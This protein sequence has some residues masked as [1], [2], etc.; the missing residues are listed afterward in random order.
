VIATSLAG[1]PDARLLE[2][3]AAGRDERPVR[4]TELLLVAAGLEPSGDP[5]LGAVDALLLDFREG[6]FGPRVDVVVDCPACGQHLEVAF[7][8]ADLRAEPSGPKPTEVV[9]DD[10][11]VRVRFRSPTLTDLRAIA[12]AQSLDAARRMLIERCIVDARRGGRRIDAATLPEGI[13]ARVGE[14]M[15]AADRQAD[16]RL[17]LR[18]PD[19]GHGWDAP[20]DVASFLWLEIDARVRRLMA[21]VHTLARAYGWTEAEILGLPSAR[22][23]AYLELILG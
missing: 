19:C 18:C 7:E 15:A 10:S 9:S 17:G 16:L 20:F 3:W 22:R 6:T 12:A 21:D 4:R 11:D 14:A 13:L 5:S 8:V 2:V 23:Q 1:G